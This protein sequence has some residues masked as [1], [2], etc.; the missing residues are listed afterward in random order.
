[1]YRAF[2]ASW[3]LHDDTLVRVDHVLIRRAPNRDC[4]FSTDTG[5]GAHVECEPVMASGHHSVLVVGIGNEL[6]GDDGAGLAA[7]R[8]V[9]DR[10]R[11]D[12]IDVRE[13]P[14]EPAALLD[15]WLGRDAVV[16]A[17]A[18]RS[19]AAPGTIHRLDAGSSPLPHRELG[20]PSTHGI[21]LHRT[22]ELARSLK[23]LPATV[24]VYVVEGLRFDAGA[25]LSDEVRDAIPA[26][27]D[28]VVREARAL[29]RPQ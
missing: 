12:G 10:A 8:L 21:G 19:T 24:I 22:I 25:G 5:V 3:G 13:L 11:G 17:D 28:M 15:A 23:R 9:R 4:G 20:S 26:L 2:F 18:M 16:I 6:R 27:A 1:L 7:A 29:H 14:G